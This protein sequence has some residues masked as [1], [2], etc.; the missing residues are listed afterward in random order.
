MLV[1]FRSV[2]G[3]SAVFACLSCWG[4]EDLAS[5]SLEMIS[6]GQTREARQALDEAVKR[7]PGDAAALTIRAE[8]LDHHNDP[9]ARAA[10]EQV[11]QGA[12]SATPQGIA[13]LRRLVELDLLA[14]DRAAA[15]KHLAAWNSAGGSGLAL[16][17]PSSVPSI[18]TGTIEIPGPMRGFY[19]MAALSPDLPKDEVILALA[20]NVITN[21]Y[22]AATGGESMEP[23]EY[24][25]LIVKYIAQ[26]R[27]LNRLAGDKKAIQIE[28]C[29][30]AA[31][32]ELLKILG[33]R[34][35]GGCG[36]D[37][38][39][40][41][42]NASRAFLT[43]DSGFPLAELEADLRTNRPF[44][45]D[46]QSTKLPVLYTPEYWLS[47]KEKQPGD[48]IDAFVADPSLCRL[49]LGLAKL[50][51][52]TAEA[53]RSSLPVARIRAFAHVFD[54]FGGMVQIRNGKVSAPGGPR[55]AAAWTEVVG[56]SPDSGVAFV[57]A[58]VTKD[59]GW[60]ASYYDSLA[61]IHG[62]TMEYL[63]DPYHLK[64]FYSALRGRVT[65]PGPARPVFRAN[66]DLM[67]LTTRLRV[68]NGKPL[69]PG[70]LAVWQR[71]FI[72]HPNG[73]YDGKL[74]RAAATWK[75][76]DDLIEA[77]FGL[78]RKSVE[79]EPLKIFLAVS[80]ME[81]G[82]AQP[83]DTQTVE[84][85]VLRWRKF[86]AQ[87]AILN[88]TPV[89]SDKTILQ[90]LNTADAVSNISDGSLRCDTVGIFQALA[91]SWQ[92][93]VRQGLIP[94]AK[95]DET[96][97]ALM[98][99][100]GK[101]RNSRELFDAGRLGVKT[102][103]SASGAPDNANPQDRMTDLLVGAVSTSDEDSQQAL[104]ADMV[105]GFEAQRLVSL[106]TL[107]DLADQLDAA[108]KG[109]KPNTALMN[110]LAAKVS[111]VNLPKPVLTAQERT[112]STYGYWVDRHIDA[113]R[114]LN[115]RSTIDKAGGSPEKL[116]DAK[117][118]L[119]PALR[120]TL[121]GFLYLHY[122]PPGA[123]ILYTNPMFVRSHDF[124]GALNTRPLWGA[125]EVV[126]TGWPTNAG[127]RLTGSLASLPYALAEAEQNFLIPTR[128]Q[129]LI[130]GDLVPQMLVTSRLPRF[131]NVAPAQLHY[132]NLHMRVGETM[133][134]DSALSA[135]TRANTMQ[136]LYGMAS[137]ARV[138]KVT[139][140]LAA[141][142][143][144]QAL[145]QVTPSE[146]YQLGAKG[147]EANS[148]SGGSAAAQIRKLAAAYPQHC[149][150]AAVSAAF[151]TPKPTLTNSQRLELLNIRTFP[152]LMGYSS[153]ILAESWESNN[154]YFASLADEL[155]LQ[156]SQL[157]VVLPEW[158]QRTVEQIFATHLEDW[159]ALLRSMRVT[160]DAVRAQN[161][162]QQMAQSQAALQ[163]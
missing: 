133:L 109:E 150:Q 23:T 18:P 138:R 1:N 93:F 84:Q 4:F 20:R 71:L 116:K 100:I 129:A 56:V 11:V 158:T 157:N 17:A 90:F 77:L 21:G 27:E 115:M 43:M 113:Q 95:A 60:M 50:D 139:D 70:G 66:T 108:G 22:H 119:T 123:Q 131:W 122:S 53:V 82:R 61:R 55:S 153:R 49:Y 114:K 74:T 110:R 41:T 5:R 134:A 79:N 141:G 16:A 12:G 97:V 65:S 94:Q 98:E 102:L 73:R 48:F 107:F 117:G 25:K 40:E 86:G 151:G 33:F 26:A 15:E 137:P 155:Y 159:P 140:L 75:E 104:T 36:S 63:T 145:Q 69:I 6:Q 83:L 37:V 149:N 8:F 59:D 13:A 89:L 42:V 147:V 91:G 45:Y 146:L 7:M 32:G 136:L 163:Q 112:S 127:G 99:I 106:K 2:L 87:Y 34:M 62:P 105:R 152:T 44:N 81:R 160:A 101:I 10:Y 162:K 144:A 111:E 80:D 47:A 125:T 19:R 103:L 96:L 156:P 29:D 128:E 9:G 14:G 68:A 67:L 92:A 51:P 148:P 58:L 31:T 64:R 118:L 124:I 88:Q 120:D 30:S 54:Y 24:L 38:V 46:Y 130:W 85:L 3:V 52:E 126:G 39:L 161:G 78:S 132:V 121:V 135:E 35:R 154:I 76:P 143:V 72:E 142:E 57:E 28:S